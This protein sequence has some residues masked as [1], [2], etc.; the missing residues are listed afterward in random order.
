ML[1]RIWNSRLSFW[2]RSFSLS[3]IPANLKVI[4]PY[5][6]LI[7]AALLLDKVKSAASPTQMVPNSSPEC[8]Q[9]L[10]DLN[11]TYGNDMASITFE[12]LR[13][14]CL[15]MISTA[16]GLPLTVADNNGVCPDPNHCVSRTAT[17]ISVVINDP[18]IKAPSL[19]S[20]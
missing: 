13:S 1:T 14:G 17:G 20:S 8:E 6:L 19:L 16:T 4:S 11:K 12:L 15:Q 7:T 18:P 3:N 9:H 2:G 10:Q 5:V